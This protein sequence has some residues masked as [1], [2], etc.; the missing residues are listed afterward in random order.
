[1]RTLLS[2]DRARAWEIMSVDDAPL[3]GAAIA[4]LTN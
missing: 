1:M 2:G 3:L 4:A